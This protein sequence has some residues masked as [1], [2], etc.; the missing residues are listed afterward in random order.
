MNTVIHLTG[1]IGFDGPYSYTM[2]R[3]TVCFTAK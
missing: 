2:Y 1:S 3:H